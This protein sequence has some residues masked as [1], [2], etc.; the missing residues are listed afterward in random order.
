MN[1]TFFFNET[2]NGVRVSSDFIELSIYK[3]LTAWGKT[4]EN[5]TKNLI[6]K[7]NKKVKESNKD[8]GQ[9][10]KHYTVEIVEFKI[11]K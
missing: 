8:S 9:A 5:A 1:I 11:T 3:G 10:S 4:K 6:N 7:W 2:K